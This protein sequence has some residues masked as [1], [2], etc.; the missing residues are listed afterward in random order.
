MNGLAK[1]VVSTTLKEPLEWNN[2]TLIKGDVAQEVVELKQQPGRDLQ[3]IGSGDLAQTL[4][5]HDLVD[6]IPAHG[7][8]RRSGERK[9]SLQGR[10]REDPT[11]TGRLQETG[12]GVLI[13]TYEPAEAPDGSAANEK[14][15]AT[16]GR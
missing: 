13:L 5:Q 12:T 11:E 9:A 10:E 8:S 16:E 2:S 14:R 4:M 15:N 1:F 6:E 7:P 3:V